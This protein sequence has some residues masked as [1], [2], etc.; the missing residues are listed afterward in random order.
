M[1]NDK[2]ELFSEILASDKL[3]PYQNFSLMGT[4]PDA[5]PSWLWMQL[6][7]NP[8]VAMAIYWEME[9]KDA[10]IFS[11]LDTRKTNVLSKN[12]NVLP[13]GE[14]RQ[15]RKTADFVEECL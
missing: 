6:S 10:A 1:A 14:Q 2:I 15:D 8:W 11:A 3:G 12:W 9:E 13:A 5:D 4:F 7:Y